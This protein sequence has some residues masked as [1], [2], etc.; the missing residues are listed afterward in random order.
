MAPATVAA[1]QHHVGNVSTANAWELAD[2]QGTVGKRAT[3]SLEVSAS[4]AK[5]LGFL[6]FERPDTARFDTHTHSH[7]TSWPKFRILAD[8]GQHAART[9]PTM[10]RRGGPGAK[11]SPRSSAARSQ[12]TGLHSCGPCHATGTLDALDISGAGSCLGDFAPRAGSVLKAFVRCTRLVLVA[13]VCVL[14]MSLLLMIFAAG[15][16]WL[17]GGEAD[18]TIRFMEP[19]PE[20]M[21]EPMPEAS[22]STPDR[23]R[24]LEVLQAVVGVSGANYFGTDGHK[25]KQYG[26]ALYVRPPGTSYGEREKIRVACAADKPTQADAARAAKRRVT[27]ILGEAAVEAAERLVAER[28]AAAGSSSAGVERTVNAVL[29]ATQ[30][31]KAVLRAAERRAETAETAAARAAAEAAETAAA[32]LREPEAARRQAWLEVEA[33]QAA[34]DTHTKRQRVDQ[35]ETTPAAKEPAW[36]ARPYAEYDTVQKW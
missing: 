32:I 28:R 22:T 8:L 31:L 5:S 21:P 10:P 26:V 13:L 33:A 19:V 11:C 7:S 1:I 4:D 9:P 36:R 14:A 27:E 34:L 35:T 25:R 18:E 16:H 29:G 12:S 20:P 15:V 23:E 6:N 17:Y 24:E 3:S 2:A 30:R